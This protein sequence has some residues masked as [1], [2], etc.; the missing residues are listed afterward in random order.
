MRRALRA[1]A[2]AVVA[3][4]YSVKS[5]PLRHHNLG[6]RLSIKQVSTTDAGHHIA[7]TVVRDA[8]PSSVSEI[9]GREKVA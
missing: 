7:I 4:Q 3:E 2:E 5:W 8:S 1:L 6:N 9:S